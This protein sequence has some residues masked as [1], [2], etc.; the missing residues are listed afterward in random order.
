PV[1]G[2]FCCVFW[3]TCGASV[4]GWARVSRLPRSVLLSLRLFRRRRVP[5]LATRAWPHLHSCAALAG[6]T[7]GR[8]LHTRGSQ[9]P[10]RGASA[11]AAGARPRRDRAS[12]RQSHLV[13]LPTAQR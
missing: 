1:I 6:P 10:R 13:F 3:L 11:Y 4:V 9:P 8:S 7:S 12:D 2:H 5:M